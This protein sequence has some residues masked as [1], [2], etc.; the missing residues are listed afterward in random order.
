MRVIYYGHYSPILIKEGIL[1]PGLMLI[2]EIELNSLYLLK[3]K[4]HI[5]HNYILQFTVIVT[6]LISD[7]QGP[8]KN[9]RVRMT[10]NVGNNTKYNFIKPEFLFLK[11]RGDL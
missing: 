7:L 1:N 5:I 3:S 8:D 2:L 9:L 10:H 4:S 6:K 11:L